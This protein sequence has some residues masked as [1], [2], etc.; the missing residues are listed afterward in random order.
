[1]RWRAAV[2]LCAAMVL[3]ACGGARAPHPIGEPVAGGSAVVMQLNEPRSLDPATLG[4]AWGA[5]AFLGNALYGTLLTNDPRTGEVRPSMAASFATTD[6][7]ATFT[8]ALRPGL[9]FSDGSPLDAAAVQVN[10][11]R[12]KDPATGSVLAGEAAMIASTEVADP[13]TLTVNMAVPA[14]NYAQV[15]LAS[16]LNWVASPTALARGRQAFDANPV[17]AGP[18][19]L[20]S[21]IRGGSIE[22]AKNPA[23][24]D[25]PKPYLDRIALRTAHD[26]AQRY[27]SVVSGGAA[28]AVETNWENLA[29]AREAG[30]P[31][32]VVQLNGGLYLAMNTRRAP[33]D[34]VRARRAVAAALDLDAINSTAY[35]GKGEPV[36][37]LFTESS[38][39]YSDLELRRTDRATAQRLFDELAAEGKAVRFTFTSSAASEI[40]SI[41]ESVQAQLSSYTG[42]DMQIK[43]LDFA[44]FP[45]LATT[46]DFD[47]L[48]W[49]AH[50]GDPDP[51]LWS[52]F[53]SAARSN[54]SGVHDAALDAALQ[55]GRTATTAEARRAAYA[56]VQERLIELT[57]VLFVNRAAPAAIAAKNVG[58]LVQYGNGS[59][60]PAELWLDNGSE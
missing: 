59:L 8:L 50:F 24:W 16:S 23:Y 47:M 56:V 37:T 31:T 49:S 7:G 9:T 54:Y 32:D 58:G 40:R 13:T 1:M 57:P 2:A 5:Q 55:T 14:P 30:L 22:L 28:V 52:G 41:A 36:R 3:T 53:H 20:A 29:K 34:D 12:M 46:H 35:D 38:P 39:F 43:V 51:R 21:W 15:V 18:F 48:T 44:A 17:G 45:E 6:G 42:V 60:L 27:N 33:F 11:Q 10:W 26:A 19:M 4:N 25:A